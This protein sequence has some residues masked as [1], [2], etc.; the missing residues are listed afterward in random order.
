MR[1]LDLIERKRDGGKLG[2]A[3]IEQFV[4]AVV[5]K[6]VPDYQISALLMAIYFRGMDAEETA[7][8]TRAMVNSG[9]VADLRA[10][11][12]IKVDKHSTGGV[13]DKISLPLAPAVAACG[14]RVPMISGRS[15][16][17]TGGTLDKLES[18]PGFDVKLSEDRLRDQVARLG[19]GF[20]AATADLAPADKVLYEMRDATATVPSIALI[21]SSIL[22]KKV[23]SGISALV[24]DVKTG[25]GAFLPEREKA[26]ALARSLVDTANQLGLPTIAWIT[27]MD[28]PLGRAVGNALEIVETVETL[29]GNG[30]SDI[31]EL[32]TLLGGEMLVAA[33]LAGDLAEGRARIAKSLTDGSALAKWREAV[34]AQGG[35]ALSIDDPSRLPRAK[36]REVLTAPTGGFVQRIDARAIGVAATNLG[37]GRQKIEDRVQP[38]VG[39]VLG[40]VRGDEVRAG[41]ALCEVHFD[42]ERRFADARARIANAFTIGAERPAARALAL[43]RIAAR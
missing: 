29:R 40:K 17:H 41:D 9:R 28:E 18:I 5:A 21:T 42:D 34:A 3:E 10:I 37:A 38:G 30:P 6:S 27:D 8:L 33:K 36:H 25:S 20:G 12:G 19:L 11:P 26:N 2:P 1:P 24:L 15:L 7:A 35:D 14:G 23:A 22:S 4:A 43:E 31:V 16:G 32:T 39:I 13:G